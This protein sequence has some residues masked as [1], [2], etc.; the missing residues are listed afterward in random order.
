M[1]EVQSQ[2][3]N[4]NSKPNRKRT[5]GWYYLYYIITLCQV[6]LNYITPVTNFNLRDDPKSYK[7]ERSNS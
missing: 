6:L 4:T 2:Y 1:K 5:T 7:D 3:K